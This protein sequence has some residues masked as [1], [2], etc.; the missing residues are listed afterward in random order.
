MG[1]LLFTELLQKITDIL[2][3][4]KYVKDYILRPTLNL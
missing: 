2:A 3:K 1:R 4:V